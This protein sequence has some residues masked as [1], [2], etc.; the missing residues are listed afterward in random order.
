MRK[1]SL[2][3][4][5]V[6]LL[7]L[8]FS[9]EAS[10]ATPTPASSSTTVKAMVGK[11][12]LFVSGF[13]SPFASIVM[14]SNSVFMASTVADKNGNFSI[15]NVLINEGLSNFCLESIDF[16]R[17][18]D[19][20]TCVKIPPAFGNVEKKNLFLPPTLGLTGK[21]IRLGSSVFASGYSMPG[22]D[23]RIK[24]GSGF[25][26][27]TKTNV[28]G[29]YRSE[30]KDLPVGTYFLIASSVY[31]EQKSLEPLKSKELSSLSLPVVIKKNL[32]LILIIVLIVITTIILIIILLG[33]YKKRAMKKISH[34][35]HFWFLG[36]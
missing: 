18:G 12:Y 6:P 24:I 34:L 5:I 19:S 8:F 1:F 29:F 32:L 23:L 30:V 11:Y 35:H 17:I 22:A 16:K 26:L 27:D 20:F 2:I 28:D 7:I 9:F 21:T 3:V 13:A 15:K 10:A 36:F 4:I 25:F 31:H 33:Y 14:S